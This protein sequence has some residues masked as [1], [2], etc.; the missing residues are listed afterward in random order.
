MRNS[1]GTQK[2]KFKLFDM[3]RD[4]KGV[5]EEENRKPTLGFF[6]KLIFRKFNQLLQLNLLMLLMVIP[7]VV[8]LCL[9][10]VG[11]TTPTSTELIYAPMYGINSVMQS[12][13]L[14][15][16]LDLS[17][18]QMEIPIFSPV[19]NIIIIVM[20]VLLAVSWGW[21]N[22]GSAYVLRGL[23]RGDAV[24]VF[25]DFFYGI[26]RNFKQSFFLGLVDFICSAVLIADFAYFY[27]MTGSFGFDFMYFMIFALFIIWIMMRFY[28]Y[29][30]LV[31]FNL[32]NFKILKNSL[33]FSMLGIKRNIMAIL[34]ILLLLAIHIFLILL[35]L[36]Y[37]LAVVLILPFVYALA[38]IGFMATYAAYPVIE[39]Y[40]I[41]TG[42]TSADT[43]AE[44]EE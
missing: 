35:I 11:E 34:G 32:K 16:A 23:F 39:K 42:D 1:E 8:L 26:K 3:N 36:P 22:V 12:S 4:G 37:G 30:L 40:M 21:L 15:N 25:S 27:N 20:F 41:D 29:N 2:K 13:A 19:L 44:I 7:F 9:Y 43:V 17:L 38:A 5:F 31:T 10:T 33:I 24:F 6:F 18:I 28:I 14:H